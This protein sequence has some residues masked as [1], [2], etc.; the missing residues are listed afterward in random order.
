MKKANPGIVFMNREQQPLDDEDYNLEEEDDEDD[1]DYIDDENENDTEGEDDYSQ[2]RDDS[3]DND[4]SEYDDKDA[5]KEE[6]ESLEGF[7][8][9]KLPLNN[10]DG[11]DGNHGTI[12]GAECNQT[13]NEENEVENDNEHSETTGGD[14][15]IT[16]VD[17]TL[18]EA[19]HD[20][21]SDEPEDTNMENET[22]YKLCGNRA[23]SYS[24]L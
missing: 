24:H 8:E 15:E 13:A 18:H 17:A 20:Q 9:D 12:G 5:D 19:V 4:D 21:D 22:K 11:P 10:D 6:S 3:S 7:V 23:R 2:H 16:G 1:D 14:T